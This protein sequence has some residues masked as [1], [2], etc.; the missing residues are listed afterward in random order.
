MNYPCTKSGA[1]PSTLYLFWAFLCGINGIIYSKYTAGGLD[2]PIICHESD[3]ISQLTMKYMQEA[4]D[5]MHAAIQN[6]L[7]EVAN[8]IG[9]INTI[10]NKYIA[11]L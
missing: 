2:C 9:D 4:D 8:N 3:Q 6:Q 7:K 1:A 10:R 11:A 5:P